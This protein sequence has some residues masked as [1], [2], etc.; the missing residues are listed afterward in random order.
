MAKWIRTA[1]ALA[2]L[3]ATTMPAFDQISD[4]KRQLGAKS[5]MEQ[6]HS[7]CLSFVFSKNLGCDPWTNPHCGRMLR[8]M[9]EVPSECTPPK[10]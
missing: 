10:G 6:L 1:S 2:I 8:L 9:G 7:K 4:T 3:A 5:L